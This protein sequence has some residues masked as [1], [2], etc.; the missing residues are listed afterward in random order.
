MM[1]Q[2]HKS[3]DGDVMGFQH[4]ISNRG[5]AT[6]VGDLCGEADSPCTRRLPVTENRPIEDRELVLF[7][8]IG[9]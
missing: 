1:S 4:N 7:W 5:E 9:S 2:A 8:E 6:Q 3:V